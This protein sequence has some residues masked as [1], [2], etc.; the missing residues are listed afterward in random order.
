MADRFETLMSGLD[1]PAARHFSITPANTDLAFRP[2]ALIVTVAGDVVIQDEL[3]T[4]ITYAAVPAYTILPIRA[5]QV[6]TGTTATVV[7]WD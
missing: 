5:V 2:R 3:G 1:A 4:N 7:G 6:R